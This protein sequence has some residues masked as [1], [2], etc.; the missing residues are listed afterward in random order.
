MI[1]RIDRGPTD[2]SP[3]NACIVCLFNNKPKGAGFVGKGKELI[4]L[5]HNFAVNVNESHGQ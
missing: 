1:R 2:E 3:Q 5:K 4:S